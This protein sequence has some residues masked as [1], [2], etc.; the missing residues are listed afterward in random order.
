MKEKEEPL[1]RCEVELDVTEV[2]RIIKYFPEKLYWDLIKRG[3]Y[4]N[5]FICI[6]P[7]L[8]IKQ[9]LIPFLLFC[10][11]QVIIMVYYSITLG[12]VADKIFLDGI[13]NKQIETHEII[14][15]YEDYLIRKYEKSSIKIEYK[16]IDKSIE[17]DDNY[18]LEYTK[19]KMIILIQKNNCDRK[20]IHFLKEKFDNMENAEEKSFSKKN[21]LFKDPKVIENFMFILFILTIGSLWGASESLDLIDKLIPQYGF[22]FT[23]N[24]WVFWC[25]LPIPIISIILGFKYHNSKIQCG[26]NII[27]GFIV[28]FMLF[29]FGLF[30][31]M[32]T[33]EQ[34]YSNIEKYKDIINARLPEN[35]KLEVQNWQATIGNKTDYNIIDVY[36][37]NEDVTDLDKSIEENENWIPSKEIIEELKIL[38]PESL[39]PDDDAYYSIYDKTIN[40]YNKLPQE[41]GIYEIYA[42]KYDKSDKKLEIH[43][44]KYHLEED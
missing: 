18:Y 31:L 29:S 24:A 10:I 37:I 4:F 15:F 43:Q 7:A 21:E 1:Y 9:I 26:K 33:F 34:D 30:S 19:E 17:D 13:D 41:N 27:A 6:I 16:E 36:Y 11:I 3:T 35:G 44:Y 23:K 5:L 42:V 32:P 2:R 12:D 39:A 28:A 14:E 40:E 22:D 25:W 8:V 20:L 38:I